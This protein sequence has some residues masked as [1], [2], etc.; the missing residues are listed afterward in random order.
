MISENGASQINFKKERRKI[1]RLYENE[2]N[3]RTQ[4]QISSTSSYILYPI[5]ILINEESIRKR[6]TNPKD[7]DIPGKV[8]EDSLKLQENIRSFKCRKS[9][10]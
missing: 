8:F 3:I 6:S 5:F 10:I 7:K 9:G 2:H 4:F 1:L